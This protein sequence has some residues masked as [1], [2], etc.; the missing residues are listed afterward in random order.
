VQQ[1]KCNATVVDSINNGFN[2]LRI[3]FQ[4]FAATCDTPSAVV[5]TAAQKQLILDVHNA[6]RNKIALGQ[7]PLFSAAKRMAK[8]QWNNELATFAEMNTKQ[9]K[10]VRKRF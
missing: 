7:V 4:V 9:C 10:M 3:G 2:N 1:Q 8:M 5:F 6:Y